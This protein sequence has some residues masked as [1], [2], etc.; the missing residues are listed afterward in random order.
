MKKRSSQNPNLSHILNKPRPIIGLDI[1]GVCAKS[2]PY[3]L[4]EISQ[5]YD[6]EIPATSVYDTSPNIPSV[7]TTFGEEIDDIARNRVEMYGEVEAIAGSKQATRT[8]NGKYNI[9]VMSHRVSEEWLDEKQRSDIEEVTKRWLKQNGIMYDEFVSPTPSNKS[10]VEADIYIDDKPSVIKKVSELDNKVGILF[11][12]PHNI[13]RIPREAWVA[14]D[15][16]GIR[17]QELA[18]NP[19]RQWGLLT[20]AL[21]KV[22][23]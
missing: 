14:S 15:Y 16:D 11:I 8:L 22:E 3:F 13:D 18:Q 2:R 12:R 19:Q 7:D 17:P 6:V 1:D 5:K 9:K 4:S 23:Y 20:D 21:L 10:D